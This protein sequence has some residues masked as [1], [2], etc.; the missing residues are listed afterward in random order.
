M[1]TPCLI[2]IC[3]ISCLCGVA[4]TGKLF[5]VKKI[6]ISDA[7]QKKHPGDFQRSTPYF[8]EDESYTVRKT[9]SGEFGG[10][11][12]FKNKKTGIEYSCSATCPVVVNKVDGK[13]IVTNALSHLIGFS[14][15]LQID[16]PDSMQV[17]KPFQPGK[18]KK[19]KGIIIRYVGDDEVRATLGSKQLL[20]T[21]R[22]LILSSFI[23]NNQCYHI[24]TDFE[25][26]YISTI[27]NKKLIH[28]QLL[29]DESLFTDDAE[30]I[31]TKDNHNILFF[32][33]G[34][35]S[36]YIDIMGNNILLT[37]YQ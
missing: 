31:Q 23:F 7:A 28:L 5:Q 2:L 33:K 16:H 27:E 21:T 19:K 35:A 9:C 18:S 29:C 14:E 32:G 10:S 36:G 17:F 22:I 3:C 8:F 20:D 12:I 6:V 11:I 26:T 15:V 30:V 24:V 13:Y 1:R 4:Q 25:K 34:E 37:T